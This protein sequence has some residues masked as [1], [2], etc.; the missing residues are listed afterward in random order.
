MEGHPA[1]ASP[2]CLLDLLAVALLCLWVC[3]GGSSLSTPWRLGDSLFTKGILSA[4]D[5]LHLPPDLTFAYG[6]VGMGGDGF[7]L[8]T[9]GTV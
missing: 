7:S 9:S 4:Q 1:L 5:L 3:P 8:L 6:T 2:C